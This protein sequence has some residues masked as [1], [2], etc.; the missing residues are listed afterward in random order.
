[1]QLTPAAHQCEERLRLRRQLGADATRPGSA[2]NATMANNWRSCTKSKCF[3]KRSAGLRSP[4]QLREE[5]VPSRT[6][7]CTPHVA[8]CQMVDF[9][10]PA[11]VAYALRRS[12]ARVNSHTEPAA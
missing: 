5:K 2:H 6:R 12:R 9:A 4:K 10:N 8:D 7:P 11:A 3:V 1:M